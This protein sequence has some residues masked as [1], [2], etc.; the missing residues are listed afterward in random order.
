MKILLIG[1]GGREHALAWKLHQSPLCDHLFAL[2][3]NAGIEDVATCLPLSMDDNDQI[4][5]AIDQYNIDFV[6]VGPEAPLVN[7]ISDLMREKNI[8]VFGPSQKASILEGS[9]GFTKDLCT[10]YNIP[11]AAYARFNSYA[12]AHDYLEKI[13]VPIVIKQDGL[14]AGKGVVVAMTMDEAENALR[15]MFAGS[16]SEQSIVIEEFMDGEEVSYF[17][18]TDGTNI[19][20]LTSA[21]D[22]KRAYDGDKG[23]NTGG[24]GAY[25]PAPIFTKDMEDYT[26]KYIIKPTIDGMKQEDREFSGVLFAGLMIVNGQP[27]LIEYN[28]RFGDPECQTIMTR[29]ET[30]LVELLYA[31]AIKSSNIPTPRFSGNH[32]ICVV[33]ATKGYPSSY[34]KNTIISNLDCASN[35]QNV[36]IFHAGTAKKDGNVVSIGGRVLGVTATDTTLKSAQQKAYDIVDQIKWDQ[37]FC[38]RDIGWR[39]LSSK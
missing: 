15:D 2:P 17:A 14:A 13:G 7:G 37:G 32:S 26:N 18:L 25:S 4:L 39:A 29:L 11:T 1:S 24:M 35:E 33:M 31:I 9:K 28:A 19:I 12:S 16:T 27:K 5:S 3:G 21:Q 23:P 30:D 22:H 36:H 34:E 38:R 8:P 10:K 6:V 20:P